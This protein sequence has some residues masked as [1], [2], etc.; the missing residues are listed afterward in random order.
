MLYSAGLGDT[1]AME[2]L[3]KKKPELVR[4]RDGS[5]APPFIM[6]SVPPRRAQ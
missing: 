5:G 1:A 2:E 3:L 4:T 6:G